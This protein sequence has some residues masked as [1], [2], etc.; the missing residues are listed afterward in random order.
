M[1]DAFSPFTP[2]EIAAARGD[3]TPAPDEGE[4][5]SPI[6]VD[7]PAP[8]TQ[9][10]KHGE[11]TATWTY[12][13]AGGAELCRILRFDFP[14][15]RKEFCPL[16]LWRNTKGL[17]W[18]W[19]ALTAPRPL[20]GLNRLADRL[21]LPVIICEGEKS[22]DAAAGVFPEHAAITSPGG[23]Q[24][25]AKAD[26]GPLAGRRAIIWSDNDQAGAK[27]AN[28]VAAILTGQGCEVGVIDVKALA[29]I[30][31]G[32]RGPDWSA[33]GW[34]A[35]DALAE[36]TDVE[37][38]RSAALNLAKPHTVTQVATAEA[39]PIPNEAAIER[40]VAQLR[41]LAEIK[42]ELSRASAAKEL[43]ISVGILDKLVKQARRAAGE[44]AGGVVF[45]DVASWDADIDSAALLDEICGTIRRFVVCEP[46]VPVAVALWIAFTW[47]IDRVEV[48]PLLLITAP[49]KRCGKSQLLSLVGFLSF[50]P[51][52]ASNISS[53]AVFRVVEAHS[54]TLLL[55]EADTFMKEN[56]ELRGVV[57]SGHTR[58]SAFVIRTVGDEHEPK[59]FSTWGA[60]AIAGIGRLPETT[61]DRAVVVELKRKLPSEKT[62][63][64]RHADRG[65]F[66]RLCRMLARFAADNGAAI[67]AARP[68]LPEALNDR[69]QD[70]W[71]PLLAIADHVGGHWPKTARAAA[72][73][74]SGVSREAMSSSA[75]LLSDISA[76]FHATEDERISTADLLR[77]LVG[78]EESP[79]ATYHMGKPMTA[80]NLAKRLG[81]Y[82][83][84]SMNVRFGHE[85]QKGFHR[86][87]F[88]DAFVRY[89]PQAPSEKDATPLQIPG[90]PANAGV[91]ECSG[92]FSNA[93]TGANPP[94]PLRA[95]GCSGTVDVA[96]CGG[97]ENRDATRKS[98]ENNDCGRVAEFGARA[99]DDEPAESW[100]EFL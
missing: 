6:P 77:A 86:S 5:V 13:D 29:S 32:G 65:Q 100:G 78:K 26:W 37:A 35:A 85:V 60:K 80:R 58:Q 83:I 25:A 47:L 1:D 54:P 55:D 24:A 30:D 75:E 59:R 82:S 88:V 90:S 27:Y 19:K 73:K 81:E 51:L 46:E 3:A 36:W 21:D 20:Y 15:R 43:G 22:A 48:A 92:I 4:P 52:P 76:V 49:E 57:N 66:E 72:L 9:H 16:T 50:R 94:L 11:P 7:A 63:R 67:E 33:D 70:N 97:I 2:G 31:P 87:Q 95:A 89:L 96:E 62:D 17:R 79:W 93:G 98:L 99:S 45:A 53:A 34:D 38:L 69:A 41:G 40:R 84:K 56:E 8:P 61:I 74:L 44:S 71:E 14:D 23:S 42:Y 39:K 64:L 18:R 91:S 10:F 68:D 12:R 28:E